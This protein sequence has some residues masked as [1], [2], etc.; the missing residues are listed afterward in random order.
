MV[1]CCS[2]GNRLQAAV[3]DYT[4]NASELKTCHA[5]STHVESSAVGKIDDVFPVNLSDLRG[6][7]HAWGIPHPL[8]QTCKLI[9]CKVLLST[10][11]TQTF[12][13]IDFGPESYKWCNQSHVRITFTKVTIH[14]LEQCY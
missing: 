9:S 1:L 4:V 12:T 6:S 3:T 11:G 14:W 2:G 5:T 10:H 7:I 8:T 13:T